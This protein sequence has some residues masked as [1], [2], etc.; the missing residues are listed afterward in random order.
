MLNLHRAYA[1]HAGRELDLIAAFGD[2]IAWLGRPCT[3]RSEREP[4]RFVT[5]VDDGGDRAGVVADDQVHALPPGRHVLD[6]LR[7][8]QLLREAGERALA[9]PSAVRRS[10]TCGCGRRSPTRR[11]CATS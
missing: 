6:L 1:D 11:R 3:P 7:E 9:S 4:M 10:P 2:A 8:D 5:Y